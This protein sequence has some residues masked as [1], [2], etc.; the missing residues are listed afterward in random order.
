MVLLNLASGCGRGDAGPELAPVS[1]TVT[2][3]GKPLP[4]AIVTFFPEA[5][6]G[7][8]AY[9]ATDSAGKFTLR[10]TR[11]RAGTV[12]G[13]HRVEIITQ[14]LT[15]E[16][17]EEVRSSGQ[18][19][20]PAYVEVPKKYNQPGTLTAEVQRGANQIEFKLTTD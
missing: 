16:E 15:E 6:K 8:P 11:D 20:P 12:L 13:S 17:Q 7:S 9:G 2:L 3:D 5:V 1:G 14:P 10:S 19:A 18:P 4:G